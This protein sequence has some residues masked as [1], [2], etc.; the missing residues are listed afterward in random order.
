MLSTIGREPVHKLNTSKESIGLFLKSIMYV[1]V[2][3]IL[4]L[5]N[6]EIL[7]YLNF[8]STNFSP[9]ITAY[10]DGYCGIGNPLPD[11]IS[12]LN[13]TSSFFAVQSPL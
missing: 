13:K 11:V 10:C 5:T 7:P 12:N 8:L 2:V 1:A 3:R 6:T 9:K 4:D